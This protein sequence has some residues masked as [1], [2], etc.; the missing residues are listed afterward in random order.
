MSMKK[1]ILVTG[2]TGNVGREVVRFLAERHAD[3]TEV[4]AAV[5]DVEKSRGALPWPEV[6][7]VRFDFEDI[8]TIRAAFAQVESVFLLRPPQISDVDKYFR[9]VVDALRETNIKH[10]AFLSLQGAE[11]NTVT[12]HYKIEKLLVASG[13]AYTFLRPSFFMQNLTTT[14]RR[15]IAE[16]NEIYI[17]AGKGKTNFVDARDLG[18]V[19]ALVLAEGEKHHRKAYELTG[20]RAY[21]YFEIADII[22]RVT[23]KRVVYKH[24][25]AVAFLWRK[26]RK[27]KT[28][29]GFALVMV[30]LYTVSRLG[31]AAGYSPEL[32]Q[33]L[34]RNPTSFEQFANDFKDLWMA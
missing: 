2:A 17:P 18:E 28:P 30:A 26:W 4:Y 1:K 11:N 34:G 29:L 6:K 20:D 8:A 33:L 22:S 10:V 25:S 31:K 19:A 27:E 7:L 9:P 24:P 16:R 21:D 23:G 32:K 14:H 15:E 13:L 3:S 12:P 5:T